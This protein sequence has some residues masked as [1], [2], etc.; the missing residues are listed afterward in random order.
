MHVTYA[1]V[2]KRGTGQW[3]LSTLVISCLINVTNELNK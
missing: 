2:E 3:S 1:N